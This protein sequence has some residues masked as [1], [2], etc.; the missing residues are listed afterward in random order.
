MT[1][2][3]T[4]LRGIVRLLCDSTDMTDPRDLA[5]AAVARLADDEV[6]AELEAA[7]V[8]TVRE[9]LHTM[10]NGVIQPTDSPAGLSTPDAPQVGAGRA[11]SPT[12]H[13]RT[14]M[15]RSWAAERLRSRI[16]VGGE[17]K[18]LRDCTLADLAYAAHERRENAARNAAE[19]ERYDRLGKAVAEQGVDTAGDL[20]EATFA[21]AWGQ[22]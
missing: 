16:H 7:A 8:Y 13:G 19:A 10:R 18:M 14:A 4:R 3:P 11:P 17:W 9:V 21:D 2:N 15:M 6:R 1:T 5:S 20:D 12:R 22:P